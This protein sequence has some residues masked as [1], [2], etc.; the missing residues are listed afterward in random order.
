[1]KEI[2][3]GIVVLFLIQK[4]QEIVSKETRSC[5]EYLSIKIVTLVFAKPEELLA[6]FEAY[7]YGPTWMASGI[8][9]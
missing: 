4:I 3:D 8:S 1:L 5:R 2:A 6:L 7:L 9:N